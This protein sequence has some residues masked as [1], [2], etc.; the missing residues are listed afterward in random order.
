VRTI[1][2]TVAEQFG[3]AIVRGDFEAAHAFLTEDAQKIY[4]PQAM[5]E[6][7][8]LMTSYADGPLLRVR[9]TE[10][11]VWDE[12]PDKQFDDVATVYVSL[13]GDSFAE[14]ATVILAT[15]DDGLRIRDIEWGRP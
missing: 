12:W 7:V 4:T 15:T 14:A 2:T 5:R 13:E 6:S 3:H 11:A 8:T 1:D 10:G 9:I